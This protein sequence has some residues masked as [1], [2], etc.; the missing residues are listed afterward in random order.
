LDNTFGDIIKNN[1]TKKNY[2]AI[3]SRVALM[4][5]TMASTAAAGTANTVVLLSNMT[6]S[7]RLVVLDAGSVL[8]VKADLTARKGL[9][10]TLL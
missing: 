9:T 5:A 2:L 1:N 3:S 4:E 8:S 7:S 6:T 10:A